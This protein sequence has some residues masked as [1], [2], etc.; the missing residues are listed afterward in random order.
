MTNTFNSASNLEKGKFKITK[1]GLIIKSASDDLLD[2]LDLEKKIIDRNKLAEEISKNRFVNGEKHINNGLPKG[3]IQIGS[4]LLIIDENKYSDI[5][6]EYKKTLDDKPSNYEKRLEELDSILAEII[7]LDSN[8]M[9][10]FQSIDNFHGNKNSKIEADI[11]YTELN[12]NPIYKDKISLISKKSDDTEDYFIIK[13][14]DEEIQ[15]INNEQ[16]KK[17]IIDPEKKELNN[18]DKLFELYDKFKNDKSRKNNEKGFIYFWSYIKDKKLGFTYNQIGDIF[19][20]LTNNNKDAVIKYLKETTK[21]TDNKEEPKSDDMDKEIKNIDEKMEQILKLINMIDINN[22]YNK[23]SKRREKLKKHMED[24]DKDGSINSDTELFKAIYP[25]L[26]HEINEFKKD[27]ENAIIDIKDKISL[28]EGSGIAGLEAVKKVKKELEDILKK[29]EIIKTDFDSMYEKLLKR[30]K[31]ET[32]KQLPPHEEE[33]VIPKP[34]IP[35]PKPDPTLDPIIEQQDLDISAVISDMGTDIHRERLSLETEEEL[36]DEYKNTGKWNMPKRA[37]LFLSRG[38]KR[39]RLIKEKME[40]LEKKKHA[41]T[42]NEPFDQEI[43]SAAD[44]HEIE[45]G[46]Y[47]LASIDKKVEKIDDPKVN[48]ICK[49]YLESDGITLIYTDDNFKDD[50]NAITAD[51]NTILGKALEGQKEI[52]YIG[53]NILEKLKLKKA[54][55]ELDNE[56]NQELGKYINTSDE[57][58]IKNIEEKISKYIAAHQEN[59]KNIATYKIILKEKD[60]SKLNQFLKH[61]GAVMKM[62][63][64]NLKMTIDVLVGGKSAYQIDNKDR[65]KGRA[66]KVGHALDKLPRWAQTAGFVGLSIGTGL[67]TG[68]LGTV[69]SAAIV[70][71]FSAGSVGGLNALKKW[72]HYTKEQNTHEKNVATDYKNEQKKI[73]ERQ[74]QALKGKRYSWKTYKAKRQLALYDQ[75]TQENFQVSNTITD[76]ITDLCSQVRTLTPQEENYI[77]KNLIQG[78]VRLD[79]YRDIGHNF[80]ASNE[81]KH[82]EQDMKRLE[83]AIILGSNKL[84]LVNGITDIST[85]QAT[86]DTGTN[87]KYEEIK[88]DLENSYNKSLIQFKRERR[89]LAA[90]YG[91][92]TAVASAGMSLGMQYLM[93]TGVFSEKVIPGTTTGTGTS[94]HFN[95]GKHNLLDTGTS[96][97]IHDTAQSIS[98]NPNINSSSII[99]I[100]YGAGTDATAVIPGR[101]TQ[102]VYDTKI[103]EVINNINSMKGLNT[104][105]RD[106]LIDHV[107]SEPRKSS[108]A[109]SNF[110]NDFLHGMRCAETV[111]QAARGLADSGYNHGINIA[112]NSSYDIAGK[113][114][115]NVAERVV[116]ADFVLN[117]PGTGNS[118]W[119]RLVIPVPLFFNT[120]KDKILGKPDQNP[121]QDPKEKDK[122]PDI[123][124]PN[125]KPKGKEQ[126]PDKKKYRDDF[127]DKNKEKPNQEPDDPGIK[128]D[129][130]TG[131]RKPEEDLSKRKIGVSTRKEKIDIKESNLLDKD[132]KPVA[133]KDGLPKTLSGYKDISDFAP[134]YPNQFKEK[135][136]DEMAKEVIENPNIPLYKDPEYQND[137]TEVENL[138]SQG[139]KDKAMMIIKSIIEKER[140]YIE[141]EKEKKYNGYINQIYD[142]IKTSFNKYGVKDI[143]NT[144]PS[145]DKIHIMT[146]YEFWSYKSPKNINGGTVGG[147]CYTDH[148]H[149]LINHDAI[150]MVSTDEKI[151]EAILK[152][153]LIHELVHDSGVNNY[154]HFYELKDKKG[155]ILE[156]NNRENESFIVRRI[157]LRIIKRIKG[158]NFFVYGTALN[159]AVTQMLADKIGSTEYELGKKLLP[160]G[161]VSKG[162]PKEKEVV[163]LLQEK[164]L[165]PFDMFAK[166]IL[167]RTRDVGKS[168]NA[169]K[170]LTLKINSGDWSSASKI[171]GER[172]PEFLK[173]IMC[174]MDYES[175]NKGDFSAEYKLTKD[176]INGEQLIITPEM[177]KYFHPSL[178]K[179]GILKEKLQKAYPNLLD[180]QSK[181]MAA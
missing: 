4:K 48:E 61:Q 110:T 157:G 124:Q 40:K 9:I 118:R 14:T 146:G 39:K 145:K 148:G 134:E 89:V 174:I 85:L 55:F 60:P 95:P 169:L 92:G 84:G 71:G 62:K 114:I 106:Q 42:K 27:L 99:D 54:A 143:D 80:L 137:S 33:E 7:I 83:K 68:G 66:Y 126:I 76:T 23:L 179:N 44:R 11:A 88:K 168:E 108:R 97:S 144:L 19:E 26:E 34:I 170:K 113:G 24:F 79:Y 178:L 129:P 41:F 56:I 72:T 28:I 117:N 49:K 20:D 176:L 119:E 127:W 30:I 65:Q 51:K 139:K 22:Q 36:R 151:Q 135:S 121:K 140:K 166:A 109:T 15:K 177:K 142:V 12:K 111:E 163:Q 81:K 52:K 6:L 47:N 172:Y 107:K 141:E 93:G 77:K 138:L 3:E 57:I 101:L 69:A 104:A 2:N 152:D 112:Y 75:S 147:V 136:L 131:G 64:N 161:Y 154:H 132:G 67:L 123:I 1:S 8:N 59:P 130:K 167:N 115:H 35:D 58:H 120:F 164:L 37:Y 87:L 32:P 149:I 38:A 171:N 125:N 162:Y 181:A 16:E 82:I 159:E 21:D 70:T 156:K 13:W 74:D 102:S 90:K 17:D 46:K 100:N 153:I 63:V 91:V 94:E 29:Y 105:I 5:L 18:Y 173:L 155:D 98:S 53:S 128:K 175:E 158:N 116:N 25:A 133:G 103:N 96:N 45:K 160:Q 50:F 31:E 10:E 165:I 150:H 43:E 180:T 78:K 86:D 122:K 73:Q